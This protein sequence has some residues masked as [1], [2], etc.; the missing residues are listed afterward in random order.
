VTIR[1]KRSVDDLAILGGTP[2]FEQPL[3]VGRPN[4]GDPARLAARIDR[5]LQDRWLTNQ[6]PVVK[7]F[8]R[9]VAELLG[10]RHCI[11]TC[12]GTVALEIA[13]RALELSGEVIV[14]SMTF[15]ATAH[16]LM[17][18]HI[19]PIFCDIDPDTHNI[20]P[21]HAE[22]L[23]TPRTTAILGV[24]LWG[25]PCDV[26]SLAEIA[27]RRRLTL[28]FDAAHA[29]GCTH[30][31]QPIGRF[32]AAEVF[33]FHA[34]KYFNTFEGGAVTTDDDRLAQR[35]R[36]M[37]NFGFAA[38]DK[39]I[40]IGINGKMNETAAAMGLTSLE[41]LDEFLAVNRRNYQAYL[42]QCDAL[43]GFRLLKYDQRE[44]NNYQ[45]VVVEV[46]RAT[47]GLGRDELL[48]VLRAENVLARRYFFP[49]CHRMEPYRSDR[50]H[51]PSP[52][53]ATE[54]V[55][56]RVLVLPTGTAVEEEQ[57]A[58]IGQILRTALQMPRRV[59]KHFALHAPT[60][61]LPG[62]HELPLLDAI[63]PVQ[64]Q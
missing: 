5:I 50:R 62:P 63:P 7:E 28:L 12:N 22:E 40:H 21:G 59:R 27:E 24:H 54:S 35:I 38:D 17:W 39:V 18:Q 46:D 53:P 36:R 2:A 49:G 23:I 8:E 20:D 25:R 41:S 60:P 15:V 34:T 29:F 43:P 9:R 30:R 33:S 6:G 19:T 11:A 44:T 26:E 58:A 4:V 48:Q 64:N 31:G 37:K 57:I 13:A 45:Y 47:A 55:A 3:H 61:L 1:M 51:T 14:P 10:V 32:G 16:A 42:D 56:G 52:L